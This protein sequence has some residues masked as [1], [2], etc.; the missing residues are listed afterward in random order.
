MAKGKSGKILKEKNSA[1]DSFL[2]TNTSS[3]NS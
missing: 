3:K 1:E 2:V